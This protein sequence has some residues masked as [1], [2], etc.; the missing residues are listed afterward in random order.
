MTRTPQHI[1]RIYV[2]NHPIERVREYKYLG[3]ADNENNDSS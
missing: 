2:N 1:P 3:T